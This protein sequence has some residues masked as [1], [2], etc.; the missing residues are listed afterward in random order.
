L[1]SKN[2]KSFKLRF[3]QRLIRHWRSRRLSYVN[4]N[5]IPIKV[6]PS[7]GNPKGRPFFQRTTPRHLLL[8]L[9]TNHSWFTV[10]LHRSLM[11]S[12]NVIP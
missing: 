11:D 2:N 1:I 10:E 5:T 8:L 9:F 7:R 12:T 3:G 6:E 4:V